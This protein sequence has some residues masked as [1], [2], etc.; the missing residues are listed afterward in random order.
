MHAFGL[1]LL[2]LSV[3]SVAYGL[4]QRRKAQKIAS[5]AHHKTAELAGNPSLGQNPTQLFS[6]EGMGQPEQ[7]FVAPCSG[8]PCAYYEVRVDRVWEKMVKSE[9][10]YKTER[11]KTN[12]ETQRQGTRFLLNDGSGPVVVDAREKVTAPMKESFGQQQNISFG[13]VMVGQFRTHVARHSGEENV[14]GIQITESI[15]APTGQLFVIGKLANGALTKTDGLLGSVEIHAGTR[16]AILGKSA[17]HA[18]VGLLS[19]ASMFVPGLLFTLLFKAAPSAPDHSCQHGISDVTVEACAD[20]IYNDEG[21]TFSWKVTRPGTF[22]VD[23]APPPGA[24]IAIDPEVTVKDGAGTVIF[25][26]RPELR[27]PLAVGTYSIN[28]KDE[29]KG[30][31]ATMS[32]GFGFTLKITEA[33]AAPASVAPQPVA[34]GGSG[35]PAPIAANTKAVEHEHEHAAPKA[36]A[37]KPEHKK[38]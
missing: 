1:L 31:A 27:H 8:K 37:P 15:F 19:A 10:G 25:S 5:A 12:V 30:R 18:R 38:R 20:R 13:D 33:A 11:G 21:K 3:I 32:D 23:V 34:L 2:V 36:E 6:A 24:K 4:L 35:Q 14:I 26:G 7:P 29:A 9:S 22:A 17:K 16:D 28:V